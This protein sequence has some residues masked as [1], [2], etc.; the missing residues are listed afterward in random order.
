MTTRLSMQ[1]CAQA[2][3]VVRRFQSLKK[4]GQVRRDDGSAM[5]LQREAAWRETIALR[6]RASSG[7][8][9]AAQGPKM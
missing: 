3:L 8:I 5:Q 2:N 9:A 6:R 4:I 1:G 7:S